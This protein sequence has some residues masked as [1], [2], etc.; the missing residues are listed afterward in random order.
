MPIDPK[1]I[2]WDAPDPAAVKWDDAPDDAKAL[3]DSRRQTTANMVGGAIRG[4]GSI[5]ATILAPLDYAMDYI[6]GDRGKNLSSLVTGVELPSR[7]AERRKAMDEGLTSLIGSDPLSGWYQ[8]AKTFTE[9]AGTM[10]IGGAAANAVARVAPAVTK[11]IPGVMAAVRTGGMTAGPLGGMGAR[12]TGGAI[13]GGLTAGAVNPEDAGTGAMIGGALPV[14]TKV[15]GYAGK[16]IGEG[17]RAAGRSI[18]GDVAP[19]VVDLAKRAE[20]LGIKIPADRI[21]D[22]KAMNAAAASLNYLPFSGRAGTEEAMVKSMN[23]ALSRTFGQDSDNVT[24]ALRKASDALGGQFDTVLQNNTLKITP[25]FKAALAEIEDRATSELSP[26]LAKII[27]NKIADISTKG[28]L[29]AIEGRAAYN[30]K[31]TLDDIGSRGSSEAFYARE[32]KKSLMAALNESLGPKE[33]AAFAKV[34]QQYGTM[35]DLEKLAQNGAEG[36][37]S[38]G[39]LANLKN[40]RNPELQE[41][42]DIAAQFL[43]TR[44]APHGAMQRVTLGALGAV[45]ANGLGAWPMIPAVAGAGRAANMLM[46]SD[47]ARNAVMGVQRAPNALQNALSNSDLAQLGYRVAPNA[48]SGR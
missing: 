21:V 29:G 20:A 47:A 2:K 1:S 8:G 38:V 32:L 41:L 11:A 43:R 9:I 6:K 12:V 16:K 5:G 26:D 46:N 31:K 3:G 40:I 15:A 24:M 28:A 48:L 27:H 34:R 23:R 18:V 13:T 22:S 37:V 42:A 17:V 35:L 30:I 14:A 4:A 33:A 7:N 10:G 25:G 45:T 39:R 44:E 19:E 36:G